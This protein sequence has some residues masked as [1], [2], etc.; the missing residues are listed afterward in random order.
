MFDALNHCATVP[1]TDIDG[2]L[3]AQ[4][5]DATPLLNK[6]IDNTFGFQETRWT[7]KYGK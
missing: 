7:I 4:R 3:A 2:A 5:V 1:L 6:N